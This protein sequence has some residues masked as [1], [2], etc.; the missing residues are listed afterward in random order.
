MVLVGEK[1]CW[2]KFS[3]QSNSWGGIPGYIGKQNFSKKYSNKS[4]LWLIWNGF[5]TSVGTA[6]GRNLGG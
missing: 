6:V 5:G 2:L 4:Y 1:E 3:D